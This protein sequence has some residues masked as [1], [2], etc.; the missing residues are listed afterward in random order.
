M[1]VKWNENRLEWELI[2]EAIGSDNTNVN[3]IKF[4]D[5]FYDKI[6]DI[7]LGM[8]KFLQLPFNVDDNAYDVAQG[9]VSRYGL[10]KDAIKQ[11]V[12]FINPY[13]DQK[14]VQERENRDGSNWICGL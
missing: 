6:V 3:K 2:G 13:I 5:K 1:A 10:G 11:I 7:D 4:E 14:K 12:D 9:F 8:G